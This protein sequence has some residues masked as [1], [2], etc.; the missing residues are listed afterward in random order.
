MVPAVVIGEK[1]LASLTESVP[2][3]FARPKHQLC[4]ASRQHDVPW[5]QITVHNSLAV[6]HCKRFSDG[7]PNLQSFVQRQSALTKALRQ[8][9]SFEKF[10]HEI[11]GAVLRS[12]VVELANVRM[13]QGRDGPGLAFHALLQLRRRRKMRNEN[14]DCYSVIQ[15]DVPGAIYVAHPA[16]AQ[17]ET[18]SHMDRVSYQTRG[19]GVGHSMALV[20]ARQLDLISDELSEPRRSTISSN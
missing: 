4:A 19:P 1:G 8:S 13:I 5:L 16:R 17:G 15:A 18:G 14:L 9:F 2:A 7:N 3:D 12:N 11:T 6:R 10:H 20:M